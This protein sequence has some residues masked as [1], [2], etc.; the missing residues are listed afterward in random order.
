MTDR[1]DR[2]R[3]L[4]AIAATGVSGVF[5]SGASAGTAR[6]GTGP[7]AGRTRADPG[8]P[9]GIDWERTYGDGSESA[10]SAAVHAASGGYAFAGYTRSS[11]DDVD[12]W[13]VGVEGDGTPRFRRSYGGSEVEV[14]NDLARTDDGGYVVVGYRN[15]YGAIRRSDAW[16]LRVDDTGDVAW[17]R[18]QGNSSNETG[19]SVLPTTD[20]NYVFTYRRFAAVESFDRVYDGGTT[21]SAWVGKVDDAG[22]RLWTDT[23]GDVDPYV[24]YALAEP[25]PGLYVVGGRI[26]PRES[27][28]MPPWVGG[29]HPDGETAWIHE[30]DDPSVGRVASIA[31]T[32][33]GGVLVVGHGEG[34]GSSG[35]DGWTA[36]LDLDGNVQWSRTHGGI[37]TDRFWDGLPTDDGGYLLAGSTGGAPEAAWLVKVNGEGRLEWQRSVGETGPRVARS[38]VPASDG[39]YLLA[40]TAGSTPS[41][42]LARLSSPLRPTTTALRTAGGTTSTTA[43]SPTTATATNGSTSGAAADGQD[44]DDGGS[45]PLLPVAVGGG[46]LGGG[47]LLSIAVG[48]W[49]L[50][51]DDGSG[52]PEPGVEH[53]G[54]SSPGSGPG[55]APAAGSGSPSGTASGSSPGDGADPGDGSPALSSDQRR[56]F[57]DALDA[58]ERA[59]G[60]LHHREIE[61]AAEGFESAV[62]AYAEAVEAGGEVPA[63]VRESFEE[64]VVAFVEVTPDGRPARAVVAAVESGLTHDLPAVRD[65][66]AVAAVTFVRSDPGRG[67]P[68]VDVLALNLGVDGRAAGMA[69][70]ALSRIVESAAGVGSESL[71]EMVAGLENDRII[72]VDYA[73]ANVEGRTVAAV[74]AEVVARVTDSDTSHGGGLIAPLVDLA[75]EGDGPTREAAFRAIANLSADFP[76]EARSAVPDAAAA[77]DRGQ[78]R[79]R[80]Q[81]ASV[82][83][84]VAAATPGAVE[85]ELQTLVLAVDDDDPGTRAE[86]IRAVG[87][88]AAERPDA[89][90]SDVRRIVGRLDDDASVVREAAA[91]AIVRVADR[92]PGLVRP[93]AETADRL[94]RLQRDPAVDLDGET[95]ARAAA[96]VGDGSR[97]DASGDAAAGESEPGAG[98]SGD[99]RVFDPDADGAATAEGDVGVDADRCPECGAPA[100]S[101]L[102]ECPDCGADLG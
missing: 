17:K 49:W 99:T 35:I 14:I 72:D 34:I 42:W 30:F 79:V 31:G 27:E 100:R 46:I 22:E 83:A 16:L 8:P 70:G 18:N 101:G 81:A 39:G 98:R 89:V 10:A 69:A 55:P 62:D 40:G 53:G 77:I 56:A 28:R 63:S 9:A 75:G 36:K 71:P 25:T 19:L 95:L 24:G 64:A 92:D 96:A 23:Y 67:R 60:H 29:I 26:E 58:M 21:T 85:P 94:R 43:G 51:S 80:R 91:R 102:A 57:D 7:P 6:A 20:G 5:A 73:G 88:M 32:G 38:L 61:R 48:A 4:R 76:G 15:T 87:A 50:R 93:A 59:R 33:D 74:T 2:R 52:D 68:F 66:C 47:A 44:A 45:F 54:G 78:V 11:S 37:E 84:N 12:A 41:A 1:V 65:A 3:F 82:L 97:A 90:G 86:A 13:L